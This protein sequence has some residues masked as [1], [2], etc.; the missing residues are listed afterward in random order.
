MGAQTVDET[1]VRP[2][3]DG[4]L[5]HDHAASDLVEGLPKRASCV[6]GLS[7]S[8]SSS[9]DAR[10]ASTRPGGKSAWRRAD[11]DSVHDLVLAATF[12]C[13]SQGRSRIEVSTRSADMAPPAA[14]AQGHTTITRRASAQETACSRF[15]WLSG[16]KPDPQVGARGTVSNMHMV[17]K[18]AT[19][20]SIGSGVPLDRCELHVRTEDEAILLDGA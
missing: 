9:I 14:E 10:G 20:R 12:R 17:P 19:T 7:C 4:D 13:Q 11:A 3:R 18:P 15:L 1:R 16:S 6:L 8:R 2:A 5:I